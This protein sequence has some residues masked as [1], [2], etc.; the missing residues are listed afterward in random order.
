M[1]WETCLHIAVQGAHTSQT[2]CKFC[3]VKMRTLTKFDAWL[4]THRISMKMNTQIQ[5]LSDYV[6]RL[7]A[8]FV[9]IIKIRI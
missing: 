2:E 9:N 6:S 8:S 5:V 4:E 7:L 3:R 1:F